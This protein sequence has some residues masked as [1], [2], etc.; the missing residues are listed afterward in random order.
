MW[1]EGESLLLRGMYEG[2]PAYV[3]SV[4]VVRDTP[5][6]TALAVWPGAECAAPSGYIHRRHGDNSSWDR[7]GE[8]LTDTLALEKYTWHSNRFLILLEP[9]KFY[10]TIYMWD[11]ASSEFL[12]YYINFQI[13]FRRTRLGFDTLDL[14]LDIVI[15]P[16]YEW[17]WKDVD[18][19]QHGIR[20][21]GI[22][23]VWVSAVEQARKEVATRLRERLY[24]LDGAWREWTLDPSWSPPRLP[25]DW[26]SPA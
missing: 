26:A 17:H 24:P 22:T 15:E 6:E 5:E 11:A 8:T 10:S 18:E 23:P 21:G 4:R 20:S 1:S 12:C 16:S 3:Q 19:Y 14:D 13:P 25:A 2:R 9:D 7:W